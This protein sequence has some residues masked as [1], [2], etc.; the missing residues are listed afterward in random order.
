[1]SVGVNPPSILLADGNEQSRQMFGTFF[2]GRGWSYEV[3]PDSSSMVGALEKGTYDIIIADVALSGP[4]SAK[5]LREILEKHPSQA[6]I[7]VSPNATYEDALTMFRSGAT[8]LLA[9]PIDFVWLERVVQQI[10]FSRRN[11][12]RE[13]ATYRFVTS[14]RTEMRFSCADVAQVSSISLPVVG[15]LAQSGMLS[16][17][18]A[19]KIRLA[20]QE[21]VLNGLEHGNLELDSQWKEEIGEDGSDKFSSVRKDRLADPSYADRYVYVTLQFS[22]GSL[23]ITVRDEG[24]GFLNSKVVQANGKVDSLACS[25]R[26]LALMSSA[27]DEVRFGKNG[28]VVTMIKRLRERKSTE[29]YGS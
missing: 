26:G 1:M 25:G 18:E 7:A 11:D 4:D 16:H 5:V 29:D 22:D 14:E 9:R 28:S 6:I 19:L 12:E 24:K 23:E 17:T 2:A 27:V 15:R 8:D 21:A 13:R 10:V 3:V 20:V